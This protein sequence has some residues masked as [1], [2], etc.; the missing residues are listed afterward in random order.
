MLS[1]YRRLQRQRQLQHLFNVANILLGTQLA[2][3]LHT[4]DEKLTGDGWPI[5]GCTATE[6]SCRTT[7]SCSC[8]I[9]PSASMSSS[10][11]WGATSTIFS[12]SITHKHSVT[13][14]G[15]D[16][17]TTLGCVRAIDVFHQTLALSDNKGTLST[18]QV[19]AR[20]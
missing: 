20:H 16:V 19:R 11:I 2:M 3:D 5:S 10:G 14:R 1:F 4:N 7:A 18:Y 9:S 17:Y 12:R 13:D 15:R 8:S 6:A